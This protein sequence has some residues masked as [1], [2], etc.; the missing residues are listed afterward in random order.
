M[1]ERKK[2]KKAHTPLE[3]ESECI[4]VVN[5]MRPKL[6]LCQSVHLY[7]Y[8]VRTSNIVA[9]RATEKGSNR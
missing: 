3:I 7:V 8:T 9:V 4:A 1:Q 6:W 5:Y 2:G